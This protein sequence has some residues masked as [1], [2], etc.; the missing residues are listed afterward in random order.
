MRK[1]VQALYFEEQNVGRRVKSSKKKYMWKFEVE[2]REYIL[3]LYIS[4]LSGKVKVILNG[5]IRYQGKK[6]SATTFNYPFR[7]GKHQFMIMQVGEIYDLRI[8][9]LSFQQIYMSARY[10]E[11]P[12]TQKYVESDDWDSQRFGTHNKQA[13][14]TSWRVEEIPKRPSER[15]KFVEEESWTSGSSQIN[16]D[17]FD[18]SQWEPE[19]AVIDRDPFEK[20]SWKPK[21]T[22]IYSD[23]P[24][25]S[26]PSYSPKK[27]EITSKMR[28]SSA[29]ERPYEEP[30]ETKGRSSI[31]SKPVASPSTTKQTTGRVDLFD[32]PAAPR[33]S[34]PDD[35]FSGPSVPQ[36]KPATADLFTEAFAKGTPSPS[37]QGRPFN[38][39]EQ[40]PSQAP[41]QI[42]VQAPMMSN[43]MMGM[44]NPMMGGQQMMGN[45]MQMMGNPMMM[46]PMLANQLMMQYMMSQQAQPQPR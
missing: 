6:P 44:M 16:R 39:F 28:R 29:P 41:T 8:D 22:S 30:I 34:L 9:N 10:S 33:S 31:T 46:N 45:P 19:R 40:S 1:A 42:P 32:S 23:W 3:D 5:D 18:K 7:M 11:E 21:S 26:V 13:P 35:L 12:P 4:R 15:T 17:P 43:P 25:D 20:E 38:P 37:T 36:A 24:E 27:S 2:S 14:A